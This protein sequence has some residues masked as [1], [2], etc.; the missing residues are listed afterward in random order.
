MS[1]GIADALLIAAGSPKGARGDEEESVEEKA[2]RMPISPE[3]ASAARDV[4]DA[5]KAEN[6]EKFVECLHDAI[7]IYELQDHDEG[8]SD[9]KSDDDE[10]DGY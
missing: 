9:K 3:F 7:C 1:G 2:E 8:K 10:G 4:Y 6:P 5:F